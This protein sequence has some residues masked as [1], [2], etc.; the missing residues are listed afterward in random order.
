MISRPTLSC[1]H[2]LEFIHRMNALTSFW[3]VTMLRDSIWTT[4]MT[5]FLSLFSGRTY[6]FKGQFYWE[7]NDARMT[8]RS[9]TP[10]RIGTTFLDCE[11][12]LPQP[13]IVGQNQPQV[14]GSSGSLS[15]GTLPSKW[16]LLFAVLSV[17]LFSRMNGGS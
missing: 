13:T 16:T 9:K 4:F 5:S 17:V 3:N 12:D 8:V 6:F 1:I 7:F 10:K 11:L 15:R 2:W 14:V